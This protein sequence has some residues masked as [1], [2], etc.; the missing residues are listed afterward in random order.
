MEPTCFAFTDSV[1]GPP[2]PPYKT[3]GILPVWRSRRASF[4]PRVARGALSTT[5]W[6][7]FCAFSAMAFSPSSELLISSL[8]CLNKQLA[9]RGLF[10]N[11]ANPA[12]KQVRHA[13]H[14]NLTHLLGGFAE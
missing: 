12:C 13:E 5:I 7:A 11:R 9:D 10:V 3:A 8:L 14:A 6:S 2:L 4:L 1:T